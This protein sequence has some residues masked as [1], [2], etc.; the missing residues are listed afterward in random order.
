MQCV[1]NSIIWLCAGRHEDTFAE[2]AVKMEAKTSEL[3]QLLYEARVLRLLSGGGKKLLCCSVSQ[4]AACVH[5]GPAA[6]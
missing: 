2:V 5:S 3:P 6:T 4:L 1:R